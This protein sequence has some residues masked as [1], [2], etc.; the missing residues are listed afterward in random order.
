MADF[1]TWVTAAEPALLDALEK[2]LGDGPRPRAWPASGQGLSTILNRLA[3]NLREAGWLVE[4]IQTPGKGSRK[5][6]HLR[7]PS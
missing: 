2:V 6:W 1:A 7:K 4:Q 3:P 5:V